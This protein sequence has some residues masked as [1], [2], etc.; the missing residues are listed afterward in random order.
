LHSSLARWQVIHGQSHAS[1]R[2]SSTVQ[3]V[4]EEGLVSLRESLVKDSV[5]VCLSTDVPESVSNNRAL[6]HL[7]CL[8]FFK[9]SVF[10]LGTLEQFTVSELLSKHT[11]SSKQVFSE[12]L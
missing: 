1:V 4:S 8:V 10:E 9:Q 5:K 7:L 12:E 2:L 3:Q 11:G 6:A